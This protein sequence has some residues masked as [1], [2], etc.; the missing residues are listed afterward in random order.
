LRNIRASLA[1]MADG[2]TP[3][4]DSEFALVDIEQGL[5]RIESRQV[6]GK[7]IINF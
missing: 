1:K 7:I 5:K 2:I 3:V 6:F 4:I